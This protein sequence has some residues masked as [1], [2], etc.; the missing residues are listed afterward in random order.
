[1]KCNSSY[2]Y[3]GCEFADDLLSPIIKSWLVKNNFKNTL[4][5]PFRKNGMTSSGYQYK[6]HQNVHNL[7]KAYGGK[8]LGGYAVCIDD[9]ADAVQFLSHSVWVTPE[10]NAVD[11]TPSNDY[12]FDPLY[13][14]FLPVV[15][16]S[17]FETIFLSFILIEDLVDKIILVNDKRS[18]DVYDYSKVCAQFF[19]KSMLIKKKVMTRSDVIESLHIGGFS[20]ASSSTGHNWNAIYNNRIAPKLI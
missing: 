15:E 20:K 19:T 2:K 10:G 14:H 17:F 7:V 16:E 9:D 8:R 11:V 18:N 1:M 5:V 6:C 4:K 12:S 13:L 3:R